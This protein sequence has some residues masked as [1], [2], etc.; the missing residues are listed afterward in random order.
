MKMGTLGT[1]GIADFDLA[2]EVSLYPNPASSSITVTLGG[3]KQFQLIIYNA[4]GAQVDSQH[5][6]IGKNEI[7]I[8]NLPNGIYFAKIGNMV[9]K[10]V[11]SK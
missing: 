9:K 5:L 7:N 1:N 11:V 4:F 6:S 10:I 3:V 8:L 2:D